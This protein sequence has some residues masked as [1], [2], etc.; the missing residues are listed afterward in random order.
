MRFL[1]QTV[2][3]PSTYFLFWAILL[4]FN[5]LVIRHKWLE[6]HQHLTAL[7]AAMLLLTPHLCNPEGE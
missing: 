1:C 6:L 5:L 3:L 2:F 4:H 7:E